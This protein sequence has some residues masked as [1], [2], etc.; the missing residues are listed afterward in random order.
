MEKYT[1]ITLRQ[2]AGSSLYELRLLIFIKLL[3]PMVLFPAAYFKSTVNLFYQQKAYHLVRKSQLGKTPAHICAPAQSIRIAKCSADNKGDMAFAQ[4]APSHQTV[5]ASC[6][7]VISLP[8]K[9][10]STT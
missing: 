5:P 4:P 3:S 10:K 9:S 2:K 1:Y 8:C 7:E 6:G